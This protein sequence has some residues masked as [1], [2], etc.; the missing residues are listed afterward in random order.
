MNHITENDH[1]LRQHRE[2]SGEQIYEEK[3]FRSRTDSVL[4]FVFCF[5]MLLTYLCCL[6]CVCVAAGA[7]L[8]LQQ[9]RT[10]LELVHGLPIAVASLLERRLQGTRASVAV[11]SSLCSTGSI[12]VARGLG[13]CVACGIFLVQGSNPCLLHWQAE[14][15]I[16]NQRPYP[17]RGLVSTVTLRLAHGLVRW[18]QPVSLAGSQSPT[19]N[20]PDGINSCPSVGTKASRSVHR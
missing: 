14:E 3:N 13:C 6:C 2:L 9:A 16:L 15:L 12:S 20:V 7:F 5:I 1:V 11:V 4:F 18:L 17:H 10:T 8:Q 19:K